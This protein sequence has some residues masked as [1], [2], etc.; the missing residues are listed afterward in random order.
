MPLHAPSWALRVAG[1]AAL[2]PRLEWDL[3]SRRGASLGPRAPGRDAA[4]RAGHELHC[5]RA[6]A[7]YV[8]DGMDAEGAP[9]GQHASLAVS[10]GTWEDVTWQALPRGPARVGAASVKSDSGDRLWR[11][12]GY[13]ADPSGVSRP[14]DAFTVF[15]PNFYA[16]VPAAVPATWRTVAEDL[17]TGLSVYQ[18]VIHRPAETV[19][20]AGG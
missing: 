4:G 2:V 3:I 16:A 19:R 9:A 12:G 13:A 17:D 14:T 5:P 10:D 6:G 7:L 11:F 20:P 18:T 1:L 8:I 15:F